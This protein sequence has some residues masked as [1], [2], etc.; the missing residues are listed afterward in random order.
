MA[1][2]AIRATASAAKIARRIYTLTDVKNQKSK[3]G[4]SS[5]ITQQHD[6]KLLYR[7][8][9]AP[10]KIRRKAARRAANFLRR[11]LNSVGMSTNLY[12]NSDSAFSTTA[13]QQECM[14]IYSGLLYGNIGED[15]AAEGA[16][17]EAVGTLYNVFQNQ[18]NS[19]T[20]AALVANSARM[21]LHSITT[22]Y[23]IS[24]LSANLAEVD[25]YEF[26][27]RKDWSFNNS[28]TGKPLQNELTA[29]AE[30]EEKMP[31]ATSK[32]E[33][34]DLGWTPFD[35]N[36]M[37]KY[38]IIQS[39]QRFYIGAGNTISF[40]KRTNYRKPKKYV[41]MDFDAYV[42]SSS[43]DILPT[44]YKA[45]RGVTRGIICVYRGTPGVT[46]ANAVQLG[47]NAQTRYN[48][49]F[50]EPNQNYNADGL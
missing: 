7:R 32:I 33:Y 47:W 37:L 15:I 36:N 21:Y 14:L 40:T 49:K 18:T 5:A 48:V 35:S 11:Q 3:E 19:L 41:G 46:A 12:R 1:G 24:N 28:A 17:Q 25:I 31:G 8:K 22:D 26:V 13:G 10:R 43:G 16:R 38:I 50:I 2:A 23:T 30:N 45:S 9:R 29:S 20:P 4:P 39:K 34:E 44:Q 27:F 6:S 42:E